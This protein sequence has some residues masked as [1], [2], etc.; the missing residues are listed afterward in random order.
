MKPRA[1]ADGIS[2]ATIYNHLLFHYGQC[3][4]LLHLGYRDGNDMDAA[5]VLGLYVQEQALQWRKLR[6]KARIAAQKAKSADSIGSAS[7]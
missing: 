7:L 1:F 5:M 2:Q 3:M 6:L 4:L